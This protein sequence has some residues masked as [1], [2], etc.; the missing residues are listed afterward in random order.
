MS[1]FG[2]L[3]E[4][5]ASRIWGPRRAAGAGQAG[6]QDRRAWRRRS[7][8]MWGWTRTACWRYQPASILELEQ[9][10]A[11]ACPGDAGWG[12]DQLK[13]ADFHQTTVYRKGS[14]QASATICCTR[15]PQQAKGVSIRLLGL[16]VGLPERVKS[17]N[18]WISADLVKFLYPNH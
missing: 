11:K 2:K 4:C 3:G 17:I 15:G 12:R 13:F 8:A 18:V 1:R 16:V 5:W 7:P 9:R 6:A 10:F 14:Y